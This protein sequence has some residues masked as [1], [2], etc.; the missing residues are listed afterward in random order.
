MS[1]F[2]DCTTGGTPSLLRSVDPYEHVPKPFEAFA[3]DLIRL[4]IVTRPRGPETQGF[5]VLRTRQ[6]RVDPIVA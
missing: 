4:R 2:C 1:G 5:H 6:R 3:R